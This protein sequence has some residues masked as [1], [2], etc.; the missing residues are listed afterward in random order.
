MKNLK[1]ERNE[2]SDY[3]FWAEQISKIFKTVG[4]EYLN[5]RNCWGYWMDLYNADLVS[6]LITNCFLSCIMKNVDQIG[7]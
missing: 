6:K 3:E 1:F 5:F 4:L 2:N 7:S